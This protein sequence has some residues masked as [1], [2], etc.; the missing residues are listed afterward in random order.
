[1]ATMHFSSFVDEFCKLAAQ[2]VS[3]E[4]AEKS[5][6]KLRSL[7]ESRDLPAVGRA[8]GVGAV[9]TPV[10]GLASRLVAG[11]AKV[12]KPGSALSLRRP[13]QTLKNVNWSGLG[14][15]AASDAMLG[16]IAGGLLPLAREGVERRAQKAKLKTFMEEHEGTKKRGLSR[17]RRSIAEQTGV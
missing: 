1:M 4:E 14:R 15:Q 11:T 12:M 3:V 13:G 8:A 17:L 6:R 9:L 2:P 5:L 10:A 7:E 16:S